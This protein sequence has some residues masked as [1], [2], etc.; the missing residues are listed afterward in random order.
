MKEKYIKFFKKEVIFLT[1]LFVIICFSFGVTYS[2]FIFNSEPHR[3]VEMVN[4][5]L[6]YEIKINNKVSSSYELLPGNNVLNIEITSLNKI[7]SFYKFVYKNGN[8]DVSLFDSTIN[9]KI[10][11]D[12]V[13]TFK[14]I[15]FNNSDD[16]ETIY[17]DVL[18]GYITNRI[19]D[20]NVPSGYNEINKN[21]KIG[22]IITI[23][24]NE[25]RL[26]NINNDNSIEVVSV[27]NYVD[28]SLKLNGAY[29][30]NNAVS[31]L[32]NYAG[33]RFY[34]EK[35]LII[36]SVNLEDIERFTNDKVVSY[37]ES[38]IYYNSSE[39]IF[40]PM[41]FAFEK[42]T[43]ID[44]IPNSRVIN[45]SESISMNDSFLNCLRIETSTT[46]INNYEF[47]SN[48]YK[49]IFNGNYYLSTRFNKT[50]ENMIEYGVLKVENNKIINNT[51]C[52]SIGNEYEVNNPV[53][54]YIKLSN[55]Y[56]IINSFI[57]L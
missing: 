53:K 55:K 50:N 16:K 34:E 46:K 4:T 28:D 26:L 41:L 12:E 7:T 57:Q 37:N 49:T 8:Y 40:Y 6:E 21:I 27:D 51:L 18:G 19:S 42:N 45:R 52:N 36:R 56:N 1:I 14:I 15:V 38:K 20:I 9:N 23:N 17:F 44:N 29:G 10:V 43:L 30:Y 54:I 2:N 48:I 3:A 5:K 39:N 11:S 24:D 22:D 47:K 31:L 13:I 35:A 25:F 32:N 33:S